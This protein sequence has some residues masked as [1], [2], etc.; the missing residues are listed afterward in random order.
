MLTVS[1]VVQVISVRE[2]HVAVR[3]FIE[4][5]FGIITRQSLA[6]CV[7]LEPAICGFDDACTRGVDPKVAVR[8]RGDSSNVSSEQRALKRVRLYPPLDDDMQAR[9]VLAPP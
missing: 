5:A 8:I 1:D 6:G 2:P 4:D 7:T 3:A 9:G